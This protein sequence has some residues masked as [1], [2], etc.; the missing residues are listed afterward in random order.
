MKSDKKAFT[1]RVY[2]LLIH[3]NQE[4]LIA[5][6]MFKNR[7]MIK[8]PG[9]G[10]QWG[11][12]PASCLKREFREELNLEVE[13]GAHFYT[14]DFFVASA[15]DPDIQVLSIYYEITAPAGFQPENKMLDMTAE[16]DEVFRFV[17][18][19]DLQ[20]GKIFTFPIDQ[21]VGKLLQEKFK[22]VGKSI[23]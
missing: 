22:A 4:V 15:F 16:E 3:A 1:I 12:G 14:T 18:I 7:H 2:G 8:F 9:G 19:A 20:A 21:Q 17:P 6:Q 13:I 10:L 11:E 23:V 5:E